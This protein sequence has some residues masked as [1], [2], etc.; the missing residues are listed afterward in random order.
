M[1]EK[2]KCTLHPVESRLKDLTQINMLPHKQSNDIII[3]YKLI[4]IQLA[5]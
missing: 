4:A 1:A 2:C 5:M 3:S